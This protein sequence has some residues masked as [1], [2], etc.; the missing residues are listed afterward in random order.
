MRDDDDN[1]PRIPIP[2]SAGA[3][4]FA[5]LKS[6]AFKPGGGAI[7]ITKQPVPGGGYT[8]WISKPE[9][10]AVTKERNHG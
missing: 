8:Y 10:N 1:G 5:A 4:I 6:L 3:C 2:G 7:T 9:P